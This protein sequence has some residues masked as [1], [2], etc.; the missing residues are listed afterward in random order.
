[1]RSC[2]KMSTILIPL[3]SFTDRRNFQ[4]AVI[5]LEV[6]STQNNCPKEKKPYDSATWNKAGSDDSLGI[7]HG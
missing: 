3:I 4:S 5:D 1:M 7:K 6:G 2:H